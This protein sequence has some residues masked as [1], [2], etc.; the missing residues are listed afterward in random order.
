MMNF[1]KRVLALVAGV[2]AFIA[3]VL[4]IP[5]VLNTISHKF[6]EITDF[7]GGQPPD[8][9]LV[10]LREPHQTGGEDAYEPVYWKNIPALRASGRKFTFLV[11]GKSGELAS[12]GDLYDY[13]LIEDRKTSQI[14]EVK[15]ANTHTSWSRYEAYE[16][17]IVPVSY[18]TDGGILSLVLIVGLLAIAILAG[19]RITKFLRL[20]LG[21]A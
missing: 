17:R 18:R 7:P 1:L 14:I 15:Y 6:F 21:V 8:R 2:L 12:Q 5:P 3:I 9:F 13:T 10:A 4:L 11:A 20:K 16:D 19:R